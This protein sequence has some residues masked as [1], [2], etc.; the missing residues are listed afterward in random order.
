MKKL[1]LSLL[2]LAMLAGIIYAFK[3]GRKEQAAEAAG[4][5]P[6]E[7]P[8]RVQVV[9]GENVLTLD[10]A[11]RDSSGIALAALSVV[12]HREEIRAY[13]TVAD[14]GELTDLRNTFAKAQAEE[15]KAQASLQV[16]RQ[17]YE[18]LKGLFQTNR[19]VAEKS[20]QSAEGE[21]HV[22]VANVQ[23]ARAGVE[24]AQASA[25]QR[26]GTVVA[27]WLTDGGDEFQRLVRQEDLL[28][29]VT[30]PPSQDAVKAPANASVEMSGPAVLPAS[31]VSVAS[32]TD[33]K[34]QGLSFFYLVAAEAGKLLP[35][36]NVVML[37]P[38]GDSIPSALVPRS[39]VVWLQG[40]PWVYSETQPDRF[41]R[42][43]VS[44]A[45][46]TPTGWAQPAA[47]SRDKKIVVKG[48]Q[49][50]LSEEFRAQISV[51]D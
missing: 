6:V 45:Q 20:V 5:K 1:L 43:E 21:M 3:I 27:S 39:A 17:E 24:A 41:V 19:N 4:E 15:K 44:T 37:L 10:E 22:E 30:P 42:R 46:P 28:V 29:Q 49:A 32:R 18:R 51:G 40:K 48:A 7:A 9:N 11:G 38:V 12:S 25:R 8:T 23:A 26:W 16:A 35:G 36:M 47:F 31:F 13:G 33:P 14:P 2:V 34:I 50:L